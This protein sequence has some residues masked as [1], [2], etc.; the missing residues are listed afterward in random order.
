[1][2]FK[3]TSKISDGTVVNLEL[4]WFVSIFKICHC[5]W[6]TYNILHKLSTNPSIF[7]KYHQ[8]LEISCKSKT[9]LGTVPCQCFSFKTFS[10]PILCLWKIC[11]GYNIELTVRSEI[12]TVLLYRW[13]CRSLCYELNKRPSA[14]IFIR[15]MNYFRHCSWQISQ[16]NWNSSISH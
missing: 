16:Y 5:A 14:R 1:M 13:R 11:S 6:N 8:W 4:A 15:Y 7:R 12:F 3:S 9:I 2:P 10:V